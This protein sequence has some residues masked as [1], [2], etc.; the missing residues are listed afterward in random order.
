MTHMRRIEVDQFLA[1]PP[2][3]VWL[4]LTDPDLLSRW[5]MPN[6]FQP[7]VGHRF[8][9]DAG[10]FGRPECEVLE[11]EE[12]A[13]LR[14]SWRNGSLEHSGFDVDDG[15]QSSAFGAM[16]SGWRGRLATAL[17]RLLDSLA[18]EESG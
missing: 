4:A 15:F 14:F 5:L 9:F 16:G 18:L 2:S 10:D 13:L 11:L 8:T 1:H 17:A 7:R 3:R 12:P 6:D